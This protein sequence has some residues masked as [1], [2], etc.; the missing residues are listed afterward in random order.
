MLPVIRNTSMNLGYNLFKADWP[1]IF[2]NANIVYQASSKKPANMD[3]IKN[4]TQTLTSGFALSRVK[5]NLS[6]SYTYTRFS[7]DSPADSDSQTHQAALNIGMQPTD[8]LSLNPSLSWSRTDSGNAATT[9]DTWQGTLAGTYL[10][11]PMHDLYL[12][13]SAIDSDTDDNS[14]HVTTYD[15][16]CQYNWHPETR[17]LQQVRKTVSLRA[18]YNRTDDRINEDTEDY[19]VS[20]VISIG[21]LPVVLY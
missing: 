6:P 7:D 4:L 18:R 21:G 3:D 19:A 15:S 2:L 20:V 14:S 17:F 11:N 16:I 10:F 13:V 1:V 12:T 5:W 9:T 8:S